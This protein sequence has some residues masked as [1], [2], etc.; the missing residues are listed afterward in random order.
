MS[1]KKSVITL[2]SHV[3]F[4][5][6]YKHVM[7]WKNNNRLEQFLN[8]FPHV[9][10][11][12]SYQ[13]L[14]K[15]IRWDTQKDYHLTSSAGV[16]S[17]QAMTFNAL[18]MFNYVKIA[19]VDHN[20]REKTYY[21][22]I[23][24]LEYYNDGC[25]F[26]Y[27]SVDMWNTY[28]QNID[29]NTSKA[30]IQ[31]GF[32]QEM[33]TDFSDFTN[34][35]K[36][37]K[38]NDE[39]IGGDGCVYLRESNPV[40]FHDGKDDDHFVADEKL[41]FILFTA[42]PKDAQ[43]E[44]GTMIGL[45]S[46]YLYYFIAYNPNSG[47]LYDIKVGDKTITSCHDK[48]ISEAYA[49]LSKAKEFAGSDS[50]I[51][52]SEIYGY[53]GLP[54][55]VVDGHTIKFTKKDLKLTAKSKYLNKIDFNGLLDFQPETGNCYYA[56]NSELG[57]NDTVL[58][59]LVAY[60]QSKYGALVPLKI[61]GAP[62]SKIYYT[63]GHGMGLTTDIFKYTN[64]NIPYLTMKRYGAISEN[65]HETYAIN[66]YNRDNTA[67]QSKFVTYENMMDIDDSA[68]DVPIVLDNY[69]MYLNSNRNQL[70]NT[71]ANAKMNMQL[72][73]E[74]N[75]ISLQNAN[76]SRATAENVMA[77]KNSRNMGMAQFDAATGVIQGVAS[78]AMS[79]G[80]IGGIVGGIGGAIQGGINLYKTGYNNTTA[81]NALAMTNATS[82]QNDRANYAFQ[83]KVATNNYEQTLRSQNA[84]L[85]DVRNH[86]DTIAHQGSN[87]LVSFQ[88]GA[89]DV[90]WQLFT[91]QNSVMQN[92][93]LYFSLF[94]YSV[95][96]Y[97]AIE[98]WLKVKRNFNYV[99]TA[100]CFLNG[101]LP[102]EASNT[103][104]T[105]FDNG[106]TVWDDD[107]NNWDRYRSRDQTN[108]YFSTDNPF[109]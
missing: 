67:D 57:G 11:Y 69:T 96:I 92:V 59:N 26:I 100:N 71:R 30:M 75:L 31:R 17:T 61:M 36:R 90:H 38:N 88:N 58:K 109:D 1:R 13:N 2:Y 54:F 63:N 48:T 16:D 32:V 56:E 105:M 50:L 52:D 102:T 8:K 49:E 19:D 43:N 72:T 83:N 108:N 99:R 104:E 21:G 76:R 42:Q 9:A 85:A 29:W 80:L 107:D 93:I 84:V 40:A 73:K 44:A 103:L 20:G 47:Y 78:G 68:R 62:F 35:F 86:N 74:G 6:T 41:K 101:T 14:N 4:D 39:E 91:C 37:I 79:G 18:T 53:L 94:G 27:Y 98:P 46:Q 33:K 81:A 10:E 89:N 82:A 7:L 28:L 65:G 95:N 3:P 5:D 34:T 70:A 77:Y 23:T 25:T 106:V 45:Y 22:F 55:Q 24:N 87:Y 66:H 15:P 51:V 97:G 64:L 60:Y 12:T